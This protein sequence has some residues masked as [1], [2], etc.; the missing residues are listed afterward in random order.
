M[1]KALLETIAEKHKIDFMFLGE[2]Y[3]TR[4][5][6]MPAITINAPYMSEAFIKE[7]LLRKPVFVHFHLKYNKGFVHWLAWKLRKK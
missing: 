2:N 4:T 1:T 6:D 3:Q 5:T 7:I